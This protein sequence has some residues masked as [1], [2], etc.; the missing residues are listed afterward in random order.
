[1]LAMLAA[2]LLA[3]CTTLAQAIPPSPEKSELEKTRDENA[4]LKEL[5]AVEIE[6]NHG[7]AYE[8]EVTRIELQKAKAALVAEGAKPVAEVPAFEDFEVRRIRFGL[9]T[10]LSDW[11]G[12]P[13][14]DGF[15]VYL[16]GEDSEGTTL[17]RKGN[18]AF[19][20]VD[21]SRRQQEVIMSWEFPA[22]VLARGWQSLPP[23]FRV[24]LP[25][26]GEVPW[27]DEVLL[28]ATFTDSHGRVFTTSRVFLLEEKKTQTE[29]QGDKEGDK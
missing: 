24:T 21:V 3:G 23:G 9:V 27:G 2:A 15:K 26:K 14:I 29:A 6:L 22:D 13:G 5:L 12:K 8:L 19:D 28:R 4:H 17:K 16:I 11:D 25:W 18:A 10:G 1:L 20:L 7:L